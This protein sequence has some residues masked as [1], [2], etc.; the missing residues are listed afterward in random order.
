MLAA[1]H[2]GGTTATAAAAAA[3]S[4]GDHGGSGG[5]KGGEDGHQDEE[6]GDVGILEHVCFVLDWLGSWANERANEG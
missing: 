1:L 6:K 5:R 3:A 2:V 4:T